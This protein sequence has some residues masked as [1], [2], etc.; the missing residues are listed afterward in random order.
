MVLVTS[1]AEADLEWM[2]PALGAQ[3]AVAGT[4]TAD[5][6]EAGKPAPDPLGTAIRDHGLDP[7]RTVVV[8]D[9]VWDVEA[10]QAA[11]LPCIAL[12]CGGISEQE[13]RDAGA[14][15]VYDDPAELL[16]HLADSPVGRVALS[17]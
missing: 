15:A 16:E 13:L 9:A 7:Q 8:G 4:T 11:R 2:L 5:D 10:A 12:T 14:S 17:E 1:A 3:D 6:V